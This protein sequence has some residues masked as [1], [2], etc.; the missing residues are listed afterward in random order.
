MNILKL[1][2]HAFGAFAV[3]VLAS[4]GTLLMSMMAKVGPEIFSQLTIGLGVVTCLAVAAATVML[5][6][7]VW[8]Q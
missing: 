3:A 8:K 2:D 7:I 4:I 6:I 1:R 5:A